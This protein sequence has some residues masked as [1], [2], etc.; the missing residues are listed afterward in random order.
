MNRCR[1]DRTTGAMADRWVG[2]RS[3]ER[4]G[5]GSE[6][7]APVVLCVLSRTKSKELADARTP[8]EDAPPSARV[9]RS[10]AVDRAHETDALTEAGST[11]RTHVAL[12]ARP[13]RSASVVRA[14]SMCHIRGRVTETQCGS[15]VRVVA[16]RACGTAFEVRPPL[17]QREE[18]VALTPNPSWYLGGATASTLCS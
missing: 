2:S 12:R 10:L 17:L 7:R 16:R 14:C 11:A 8:S 15:G 18:T 1:R 9:R 5:L 6:A 13:R 3:V 4:D